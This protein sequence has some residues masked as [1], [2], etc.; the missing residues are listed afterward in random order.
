MAPYLDD[1]LRKTG[2]IKTRS[3]RDHEDSTKFGEVES[4][5]YEEGARVERAL[6]EDIPRGH[7]REAIVADQIPMIGVCSED[8]LLSTIC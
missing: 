1:A 8:I 4:Q 2:R 6:V 7:R 5:S 3:S